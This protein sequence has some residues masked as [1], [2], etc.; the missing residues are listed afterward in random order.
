MGSIL[1]GRT[2]IRN[3]EIFFKHTSR[4]GQ[5]LRSISKFE[6]VFLDLGS[7]LM[8]HHF[9]ADEN[10]YDFIVFTD[11]QYGKADK[12]LDDGTDGLRFVSQANQNF[13]Q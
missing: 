10:N 12:E 7:Y 5:S 13:K 3:Y 9:S 8:T 2:A 4:A 1:D 11:P 6:W